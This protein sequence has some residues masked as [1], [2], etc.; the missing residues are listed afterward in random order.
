VLPISGQIFAKRE[1]SLTAEP[2]SNNRK[3][4]GIAAESV[5]YSI[6]L[7]FGKPS[8]G[9]LVNPICRAL[10]PRRQIDVMGA[11]K[12]AGKKFCCRGRENLP[13]EANIERPSQI[14]RSYI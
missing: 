6:K 14:N 5:F 1:L 3:Q 12:F 4:A 7:M 13:H 8:N 2:Y 9:S 10:G 11:R